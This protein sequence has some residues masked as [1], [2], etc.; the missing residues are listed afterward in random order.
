MVRRSRLLWSLLLT[1][2]IAAFFILLQ[3]LDLSR[4][5]PHIPVYG[6]MGFAFGEP[7]DY[8]T[9]GF[10]TG[11]DWFAAPG[12][13]IFAVADGTVVYV[14]PL[15]LDGPGEGRGPH[16][17]VIDHG[18]FLTTYSHNRAALVAVGDQVTRGQ[19]IAELGSE[20]FSR[21]PHLHLEKVLPP[22]TGDWRQPFESCRAYVNPGDVWGWF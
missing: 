17:I 5:R 8:Q 22:F 19:H 2:L 3:Q 4:D 13:S 1:A 6:V 10:H 18:G 14:G 7:V 20:G 9:C 21:G 11:Q 16:A 15:W 12:A